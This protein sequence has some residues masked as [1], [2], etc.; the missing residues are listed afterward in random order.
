MQKVL[1]IRKVQLD[2]IFKDCNINNPNE[3]CGLLFG[4]D[5][6]VETVKSIK[7]A[8]S[9]PYTYLLD[10]REQLSAVREMREQ[11]QELVGIYHSHIA[12]E[13][14]P[15]KTDVNLAYYP[16]AAYMIISLANDEP[17]CKAYNIINNEITE[18]N[19][20]IKN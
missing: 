6:S 7:N 16:D 12:S 13:A 18:I 1:T 10:A 15:S 2:E 4:N 5:Y 9:S 19:L 11:G 17:V 14:Y 8:D 3:A 20:D